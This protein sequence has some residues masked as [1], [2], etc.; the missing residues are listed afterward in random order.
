MQKAKQ[1]VAVLCGQGL[2][3]PELAANALYRSLVSLR[4]A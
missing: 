1:V 2:I 3:E 4:A